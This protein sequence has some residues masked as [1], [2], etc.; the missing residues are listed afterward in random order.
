MRAKRRYLGEW[1]LP[2]A[3]FLGLEAEKFSSGVAA[4]AAVSAQR[5]ARP[6]RRAKV[7]AMGG[8]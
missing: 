3:R 7:L 2:R 6:T 5:M 8:G 4:E 1:R